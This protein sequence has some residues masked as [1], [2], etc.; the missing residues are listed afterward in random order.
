MDTKDTSKARFMALP[1]NVFVLCGLVT[2]DRCLLHFVLLGHILRNGAFGMW[3]VS[4]K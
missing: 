2:W 1:P 3:E 4:D